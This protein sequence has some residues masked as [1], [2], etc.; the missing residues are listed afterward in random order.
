MISRQTASLDNG[1]SLLKKM[2]PALA[3]LITVALLPPRAAAQSSAVVRPN[4][5]EAG[6]FVGV[7]EGLDATRVLWGGN[8]TY[9]A[10]TRILPYVEFSDFPAILR[11]LDLGGLPV[12]TRVPFKD[13]HAGVHIRFPY[14]DHPL[15]PYAVVGIGALYYPARTIFYNQNVQPSIPVGAN[16]SFAANFGGG[17]RYYFGQKWGTRLEAKL[18]KPTGEFGGVF[19][20]VEVGLFYQFR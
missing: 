11:H 9:A 13:F 7:T 15:V 4:S 10:T 3:V 5:I 20:K 12:Y 16:A 14:H 17:L 2:C 18:Y 8:L 6:G 1:G 19:G